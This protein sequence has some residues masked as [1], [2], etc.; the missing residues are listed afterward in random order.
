MKKDKAEEYYQK[1]RYDLACELRELTYE[2][3]QVPTKE[4]DPQVILSK[5]VKY[6]ANIV[7]QVVTKPNKAVAVMVYD[8][9]TGEGS[10]RNI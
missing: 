3:F 7:D 4:N 5:V 10:I 2:I 8:E 6:C 1:G 9:E